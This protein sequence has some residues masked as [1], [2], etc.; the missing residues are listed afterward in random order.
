MFVYASSL[1]DD[2]DGSDKKIGAKTEKDSA[3][4]IKSTNS[5]NNSPN[6]KSTTSKS[7]TSKS[8]AKN[9]KEKDDFSE[10]IPDD[11]ESL[12][13]NAKDFDF[14]DEEDENVVA[15]EFELT[16]M[17]RNALISGIRGCG[18]S[19]LMMGVAAFLTAR[20]MSD[21]YKIVCIGDAR[22]WAV[23]EN[24]VAF[25]SLEVMMAFRASSERQEVHSKDPSEVFFE[26]GPYH[27]PG[28]FIFFEDLKRWMEVVGRRAAL[29]KDLKLV[30]FVDQLEELYAPGNASLPNIKMAVSIF[31]M[32]I[33]LE[34]PIIIASLIPSP[35][36]FSMLPKAL[37]DP[38]AFAEMKMPAVL[39]YSDFDM[40]AEVFEASRRF[41][42]DED[43]LMHDLRMWTG[44]VP[45]QVAKFFSI[46]STG[47][48]SSSSSNNNTTTTTTTT[49]TSTS[50]TTGTS[51]NSSIN[52]AAKLVKYRAERA[53]AFSDLVASAVAKMDRLPRMHFL[54]QICRM[55]LHIPSDDPQLSPGAAINGLE[56]LFLP[57]A[58]QKFY[59]PSEGIVAYRH[60]P[61]AVSPAAHFAFFD[62]KVL[63][64]IAGKW[65]QVL[66]A[67]LGSTLNSPNVCEESKRRVSK[68]Y[69]QFRLLL[70][71]FDEDLS[72]K[73]PLDQSSPSEGSIHSF[74]FAGVNHF[75][76]PI[77]FTL[78]TKNGLRRVIFAGLSPT[79]I[80][81][82]SGKTSPNANLPLL[83]VPG[84]TD[85]CFYDLFLVIPAD[86]TLYAI[87]TC[88][89]AL[90]SG[91][92]KGINSISSNNSSSSSSNN[93]NTN[94]A[95]SNNI[96]TFNT[97][98]NAP[99][100][101]ITL[102]DM[103][104]KDLKDAGYP[105]YSIKPVYIP[106]TDLISQ[107]A[108]KK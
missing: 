71:S 36:T 69:A 2:N 47:N 91:E 51:T 28:I 54:L 18:K 60:I 53:K 27:P 67:V 80:L 46:C 102:L 32:L 7:S 26:E 94:N 73:E 90:M 5:R 11:A 29:R 85:F 97:V 12:L 82:P 10:K 3:K 17:P 88:P 101:P 30:I 76:T 79:P 8:K 107:L 89:F 64:R 56:S 35:Q 105:K 39:T 72:A 95:S 50:T 1:A 77:K 108:H 33:S 66:E 15:S 55:I 103:W 34:Y 31:E 93:N 58:L 43:P 19:H 68:F 70:L 87:T 23:S 104:S 45:A 48:N 16:R 44:G 106:S 42:N 78:N 63:S 84:R 59:H 24:P 20:N 99:L 75:G 62:R 22:S 74:N 61:T 6:T 86:K 25:F 21:V 14:N 96:G 4:S 65:E 49:S 100:T 9:K 57:S 37:K 81:I 98:T 38:S 13:K 83:F 40:F 41:T 92:A 52:V